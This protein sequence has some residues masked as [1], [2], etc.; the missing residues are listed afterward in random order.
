MLCLQCYTTYNFS[1]P[2]KGRSAGTKGKRSPTTSRFLTPGRGPAQYAT[3]AQ[4]THRHTQPDTFSPHPPGPQRSAG[5]SPPLPGHP[6]P[7]PLPARRQGPAPQ[8]QGLPRAGTARPLALLPH[9]EA[10]SRGR[11]RPLSEGTDVGLF[12]EHPGG[13]DHRLYL[14]RGQRRRYNTEHAPRAHGS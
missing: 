14:Y 6:G 11:P 10:R 7:L 9:W 13:T 5:S 8:P 12:H 3:P 4:H 2:K 1:H